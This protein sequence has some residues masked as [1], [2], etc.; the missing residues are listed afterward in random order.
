MQEEKRKIKSEIADLS[1]S[2]STMG[3]MLKGT[4]SKVVLGAKKRGVGNR[5]SYLL[6]YKEK[7]NKTRTLY[8]SKQRLVEV[9][10]M[11]ANYQE[12][13]QTL[14]RIIELNVR[15]FKMK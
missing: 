1:R 7:G 13:K 5:E 9:E 12:A 15:L 14:E 10:G 11:I 2:L 8:V 6:T 3:G 4:V